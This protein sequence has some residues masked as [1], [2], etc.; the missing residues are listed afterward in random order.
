MPPSTIFTMSN[1][2]QEQRC[3]A[4]RLELKTWESKFSAKHAGRKAGRD[5]IKADAVICMQTRAYDPLCT[6][7]L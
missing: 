7:N 1:T 3:N 5:D 4:L 2:E 6:D